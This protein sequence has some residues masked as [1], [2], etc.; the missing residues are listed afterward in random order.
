[1][2]QLSGL[3][4]RENA[5]SMMFPAHRCFFP[6][7]HDLQLLRRFDAL[8]RSLDSPTSF[9]YFVQHGSSL[10]RQPEEDAA[11]YI[12]GGGGAVLCCLVKSLLAP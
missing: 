11:S 8:S 6:Q 5:C 4:L 2:S 9:T 10:G 1:M 7:S 3:E 12:I